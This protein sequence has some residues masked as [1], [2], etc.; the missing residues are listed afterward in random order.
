M[1]QA[2]TKEMRYAA[3]RATSAMLYELVGLSTKHVAPWAESDVAVQLAKLD[4][5]LLRVSSACR[6]HYLHPVIPACLR[7]RWRC[8]AV[9]H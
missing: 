7:Y 8:F 6:L 4:C 5:E 1:R 2:G 9:G 3:A